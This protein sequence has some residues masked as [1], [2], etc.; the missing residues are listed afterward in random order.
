MPQTNSQ[1]VTKLSTDSETPKVIVKV[2]FLLPVIQ[3]PN[4]NLGF[5]S[6][7]PY[8]SETRLQRNW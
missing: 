3:A 6:H 1:E 5:R 7:K 4:R 2:E 8:V